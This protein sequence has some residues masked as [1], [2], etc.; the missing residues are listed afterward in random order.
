[1][2]E[3]EVEQAIGMVMAQL[4]SPAEAALSMLR[5]RAFAEGRLLGEVARD[6]LRRKI[7]FAP[8]AQGD[9]SP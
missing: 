4:R 3:V 7:S 6:V 2:D 8:G 5:A 9:G 1:V